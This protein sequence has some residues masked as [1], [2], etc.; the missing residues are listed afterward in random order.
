MYI[1]VED[2]QAD[3]TGGKYI[4]K[5]LPP[6]LVTVWQMTCLGRP[7]QLRYFLIINRGAL[8]AS[9]DLRFILPA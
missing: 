7:F 5:D 2:N 9:C 4:L 1:G 3:K 6:L 8:P